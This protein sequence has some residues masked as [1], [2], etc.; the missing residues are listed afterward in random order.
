MHFII[1]RNVHLISIKI[2][3]HNII[4]LMLLYGRMYRVIDIR[5]NAIGSRSASIVNAI[6]KGLSVINNIVDGYLE[7]FVQNIFYDLQQILLPRY[8]YK[9]SCPLLTLVM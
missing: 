3:L 8:F 9:N 6:F 5:V 2:V 7:I 1:D 4:M